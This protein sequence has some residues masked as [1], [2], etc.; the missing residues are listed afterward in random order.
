MKTAIVALVAISAFYVLVIRPDQR[1][2]RAAQERRAAE[3]VAAEEAARVASDESKKRSSER[4]LRFR[5]KELELAKEEADKEV[6]LRESSEQLRESSEKSNPIQ[7]TDAAATDAPE[8][9]PPPVELSD[10]K[11]FGPSLFIVKG[12]KGSGS[13]F[14]CEV[15]GQ[16]VCLTNAHVLS[17]NKSLT[18]VTPDGGALA[19][20]VEK[21]HVA[22]NRDLAFF[23]LKSELPALKPAGTTLKIDIGDEVVCLGNSGGG[24]VVTDVRGTVVGV[25][26]EEI[27]V[28]APIVEGNSG[29]PVLHLKSGSVLGVATRSQ[30]DAK[31]TFTT[32]GTRFAE[33]RRFCARIEGTTWSPYTWSDFAAEAS[34]IESYAKHGD[35]LTVLILEVVSGFLNPTGYDNTSVGIRSA[36]RAFIA[37]A[38]SATITSADRMRAQAAFLRDVAFELRKGPFEELDKMRSKAG[39][40]GAYHKAKLEEQIEKREA[41][42]EKIKE[43][44]NAKIDIAGSSQ[45]PA[46]T[47]RRPGSIIPEKTPTSPSIRP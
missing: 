26:P 1:A 3:I 37:A 46:K 36:V 33:V 30:K 22:S 17:G 21:M 47:T 16:A 18:F 20:A 40:M 42:A 12:D 2:K 39:S 8:P 38:T 34:L 14:I 5:L 11:K 6:Q 15:N 19:V 7:E 4:D 45:A 35:E 9:Q 44:A 10:F 29:S 31:P 43:L 41:M 32:K 23:A 28:D 24:G 13:G 25:G 27:E